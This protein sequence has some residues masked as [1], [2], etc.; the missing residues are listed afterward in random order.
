VSPFG[1]H[2]TCPLRIIFDRFD[3]LKSTPSRVK[4]SEA[5]TGP[6]PSLDGSVVLFDQVVQIPYGRQRQRR[7]SSPACFSSQ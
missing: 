2:Q 4:G 7:L 1:S 6:D 3:S 5:L